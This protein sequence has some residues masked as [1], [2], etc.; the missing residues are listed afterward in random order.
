[1]TAGSGVRLINS[2]TTFVSMTIMAARSSELGRRAHWAA[3]GKLGIDAAERGETG[4][5]G[6]AEVLRGRRPADGAAQ[7]VAGFLLHRAAVLGR[8][9][10]QPA[11]QLVV[12]VADCDARH[13][14]FR[15]YLHYALN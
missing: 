14:R 12:E 2:E 4:V 1:M 5:D 8:A 3:F 7:D 15:P 9:H 11:L 6:P 13:G 10:T